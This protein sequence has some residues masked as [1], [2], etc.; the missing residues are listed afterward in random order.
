MSKGEV[1]VMFL[2]VLKYYAI[3]SVDCHITTKQCQ[4]ELEIVKRLIE[5]EREKKK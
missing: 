1:I 3:L 4:H 2:V 5:K